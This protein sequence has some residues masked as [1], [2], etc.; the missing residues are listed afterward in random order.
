MTASD[1]QEVVRQTAEELF[2]Q[3]P[4]WMTFYRETFGLQGVIRRNYPTLE[5]LAVFE[6]T[7]TY[8]D[9]QQ[10]VKK[11][12]ERRPPEPSEEEKEK[13]KQEQ[14]KSEEGEQEEDPSVETQVITVRIPRCLHEALREEAF[15]HRTSI[16]KLCVSK[17]LQFIDT[18]MVPVAHPTKERKKK[19]KKKKRGVGVDL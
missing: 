11:L 3:N 16:N 5:D 19:A 10:M 15:E 1:K 12:R 4:D 6:E 9:V 8:R 7:D 13:Q 17:L 14:N 18:K 2:A